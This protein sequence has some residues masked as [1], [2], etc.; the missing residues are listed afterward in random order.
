[1]QGHRLRVLIGFILAVFA[2]EVRAWQGRLPLLRVFWIYG[3]LMS[4]GIGALYLLAAEAGRQGLQQALL[5]VLASYTVWILVAVWRCSEL[6]SPKWRLLARSL[7]V[8][9]ALN[10]ILV[11]GFLELDL[12]V[13]R[14]GS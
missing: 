10:T 4:A 7:T 6:T 12:L 8:A 11:I 14:M 13:I 1:M 3:V 9:W 2:P 5:L